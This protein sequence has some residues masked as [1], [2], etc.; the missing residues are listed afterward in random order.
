[1]S[2]YNVFYMCVCVCVCVGCLYIYIYIYMY[3]YIGC[4]GNS[5]DCEGS[6][7]MYVWV[8]VCVCVCMYHSTWCLNRECVCTCVCMYVWR[9]YVCADIDR[10]QHK[11]TYA[12]IY[13]YIYI[14]IYI[15]SC[16]EPTTHN[17]TN[18][19]TCRSLPS[20]WSSLKTL[21]A[22]FSHCPTPKWSSRCVGVTT[23]A[24]GFL[25]WASPHC[26]VCLCL[27]YCSTSPN[28]L[29][30]C[31]HKSFKWLLCS[32]NA[33]SASSQLVYSQILQMA[34]MLNLSKLV[35]PSMAR[36]L[37]FFALASLHWQ[38]CILAINTRICPRCG[39]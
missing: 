35:A 27:A 8:C 31:M 7:Y 28:A 10:Q 15:H 29:S 17:T 38:A 22:L 19:H 9:V 30:S 1:M 11:Y 20:S 6:A 5:F 23:H 2:I 37:N 4:L 39:E 33:T 24:V 14:Y 13:T 34:H 3:M 16:L 18:T 21:K 32:T 26:I 25:A 36:M 12:C